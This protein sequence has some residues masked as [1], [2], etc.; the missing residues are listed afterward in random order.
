MWILWSQ[1]IVNSNHKTT[2]FQPHL[3]SPSRNHPTPHYENPLKPYVSHISQ[4]SILRVVSFAPQ[5]FPYHSVLPHPPQP[6]PWRFIL[7]HPLPPPL[8]LHHLLQLQLS[9]PITKLPSTPSPR[10]YLN[11]QLSPC[12]SAWIKP[13][14]SHLIHILQAPWCHGWE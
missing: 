12:C 1:H 4:S 14:P 11:L 8:L 13:T 7:R 2:S 3:I 9:S 10:P 6:I 5:P